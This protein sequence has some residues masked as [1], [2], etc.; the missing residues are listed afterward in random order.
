MEPTSG[1]LRVAKV[2]GAKTGGSIFF[3]NVKGHGTDFYWVEH[4]YGMK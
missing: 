4:L 1:N 2:A 3:S